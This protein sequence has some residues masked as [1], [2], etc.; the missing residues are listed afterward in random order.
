LK[1]QGFIK[2]LIN[3]HLIA[4]FPETEINPLDLSR[5]EKAR[6]E[7]VVLG[8]LLILNDFLFISA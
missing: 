6:F 5:Q 2:V 7:T 1:L 8:N 3:K 4:S